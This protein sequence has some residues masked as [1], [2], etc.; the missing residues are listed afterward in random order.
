M[1]EFVCNLC[2]AV[3]PHGGAA[4]PRET[5]GC[6]ACGSNVR[7]RGL[8]HALSMELFGTP[9]ALP[10]FP[11]VRSLRGLGTSDAS[12][13]AGGL[14]AKFDYRNTFF[15]REPRFDIAQAPPEEFGKYDFV[16]SSEVFE[17]VAPPTARAFE[18]A[19]RLLK[20]HGV[21]LFTVPYELQSPAE[22]YPELFEFALAEVGGRMVLVNRTRAGEMQV[23]E[24]PV[25]HLSGAGQALEMRAFSEAQL[26]QALCDAG[27]ASVRV[28]G[29]NYAPFGILHAE[30]WSLPMAARKGEFAFSRDAA[31]DVV[32]EWR[33]LRQNVDAEMRR[34]GRSR[35]FRAGRK[36]GLL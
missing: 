28:Y 3:N 4:M 25:F 23:F 21:L 20:P 8:I 9:L 18:K 27:F 33:G 10:E 35:W 13:Y 30:T 7:T 16:I 1:P 11:R 17:H 36:L 5:P 22:H 32:E 14:A 24:D 34:L 26:R 15:D 6:A 12:Q 19:F 2:G 31:R 29:E